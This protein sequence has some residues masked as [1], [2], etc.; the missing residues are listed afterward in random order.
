MTTAFLVAMLAVVLAE[1]GDKTQLLAMAFA[2]RFR[3]QTVLWAVLVATLA[4]HLMAVALGNVITH[5]VPI[6]WIKLAAGASFVAFAL[7]T[8]R[9]DHLE[10]EEKRQGRSPFWT[11]A[12]AFFLAEMGDKTQLMTIALAAEQAVK[13]GGT[14][15]IVKAQQIV[16]T[17]MGTTCG[18][19]I[20]DSFGIVVGIVL[21]RHIPERLVKWVAACCFAGF[22]LLGLH[23][24]S[25]ELVP[26]GCTA[27]HLFL[28]ASVPLVV[29]AM[30]L[31][32]R[33]TRDRHG[34]KSGPQ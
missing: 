10:G 3:W 27:H 23:D 15:W 1:M 31:V 21:H 9:G 11:V 12:V 30:I 2:T 22:G 5:Y 16:P 32:V 17:W 7:W 25:D 19:L 33:L 14:G 8:I 28:V 18:M 20:A 26:Q 34:T 6:A 4:N 29:A 13:V 24:A